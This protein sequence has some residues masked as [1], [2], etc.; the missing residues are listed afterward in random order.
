MVL[1]SQLF[2]TETVIGVD[3]G[4]RLTKVVLAESS[5]SGRWKITRAVSCATPPDGVKDGIV[6]ERY[7]VAQALKNLLS[8]SGLGHATGAVAAVSGPGVMV[9]HVQLPKMTESAL[10][11][12]VKYEAAKYIA[13]SVDDSCVEFEILG[14]T[15]GAEDKMDV[16][17]VAA[18]QEMINSRIEALEMADLEPIS[19]DF[20]AFAVQRALVDVSPTRPGEGATLAILSIGASS[21]EL[22]IV[23]N[24]FH[25]LT[26]S[27]GIAGDQFTNAL[28][29]ENKCTWDEAEQIKHI[30]DMSALLNPEADPEATKTARAVQPVLDE[31]MREVRRSTN[32]FR[33][34]VNEGSISLPSQV[35]AESE[36]GR[37]AG[38]ANVS[39]LIITGGSALLMGLERYMSARL[40][41]PVEIWNAFDNPLFDTI[42]LAPD[43]VEKEH[44]IYAHCL[45]LALKE[46]IGDLSS[47]S[48]IKK[49][50]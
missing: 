37:G 49:A 11:K 17:L 41:M 34:Q 20:E 46:T 6:V 15:V 31:I 13:T 42:A 43:V 21:S 32:Y 44:P 25:A 39:R 14:P 33:S 22:N 35:L 24:G 9:R 29:T 2:G 28:K 40:G 48:S 16:M 1:L 8:I 50:A 3:I 36:P 30:V 4:S 26:R 7:A 19:M 45:G 27:I 23:A 38:L 12:S 18:P 5:G 10:R 47:A